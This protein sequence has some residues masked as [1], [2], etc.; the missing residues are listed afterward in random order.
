MLPQPF[1]YERRP[2]GP[3]PSL[4]EA[5]RRVQPGSFPPPAPARRF[6]NFEPYPL[7]S[8][9]YWPAPMAASAEPSSPSWRNLVERT[10]EVDGEIAVNRAEMGE[11]SGDLEEGEIVEEEEDPPPKRPKVEQ[12][13]QKSEAGQLADQDDE[14]RWYRQRQ[15]T[16]GL[17]PNKPSIAHSPDSCPPRDPSP[18]FFHLGKPGIPLLST[19]KPLYSR[20]NS[21]PH[22]ANYERRASS[23]HHWSGD[24]WPAEAV[25]G[26]PQPRRLRG[27]S[28]EIEEESGS[29]LVVEKEASS[30]ETSSF[31]LT[32]TSTSDFS[33]SLSV[34]PAS[35]PSPSCPD[36][37]PVPLYSDACSPVPTELEPPLAHEDTSDQGAISLTPPLLSPLSDY[38]LE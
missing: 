1:S 31:P 16:P 12:R 2:D 20:S 8:A 4:I 35:S 34:S 26:L 3:V 10:G 33:L 27:E 37:G 5:I 21:P 6:A 13:G 30:S 7:Q 36:S 14:A 28:C 38:Y 22:I 23:D 25:Q 18:R 32:E 19:F 17:T 11:G 24:R 29:R 15:I 9:H